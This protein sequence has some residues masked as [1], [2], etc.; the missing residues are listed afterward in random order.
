MKLHAQITGEGARDALLIHG[1]N[2][3]SGDWWEVAPALERRGYRVNAIDLRGH[4]RSARADDYSLQR[5]ADD[6]L[7][8]ITCRPA[9][10][11]GHS[12]GACVLERVADQLRP[13]RAIYLDPPW[14]PIDETT[15]AQ[16]FPDLNKIPH[17][18]DDELREVLR[19]DFPRWNV[20]AIEAD[21]A[22]WRRWDPATGDAILDTL[23]DSMPNR[24]TV[25][26]SLLIVADPSIVC[27]K[28][29]QDRARQLGFTV[30][31]G[32]GLSHSLFRDSLPTFLDLLDGWL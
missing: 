4:G 31:S 17:L 12:L 3:D 25:A 14:S 29:E 20:R 28:P 19:R 13:E 21:I 5:Y 2:C 11:I 8:T 18:T 15:A 30:R 26:P 27:L 23:R 9:V 10:A 16:L 7:E 24:P 1:F 32:G 6:L 22:S